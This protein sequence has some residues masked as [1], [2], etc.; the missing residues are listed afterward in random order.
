MGT[1]ILS[2]DE[3]LTAQL[4]E[5]AL[6]REF[7][8]TQQRERL[9]AASARVSRML[10]EATDVMAA[11]PQ[12]LRAL[13]EAAEV[14]RTVL[15]LAEIGADN[16]RWL[17]I[18]S[19]WLA[20]GIGTQG[21]VVPMPWNARKSDCFCSQLKTGRSVYLCRGDEEASNDSSIASAFAKSSIIVPFL[22]DGE[23]MGVV[24]FDACR[25]AREFDPAVISA[26]EIA[27][28]VIGAALHRERLIET[29]RIEREQAAEQR[30]SQ[31]ANANAALRA[32]LE[33]LASSPDPYNF[34]GAVLQETTR[35]LNAAA[36][37]VMMLNAACDEWRVMANVRDGNIE[38]PRFANAL[39]NTEEMYAEM[40]SKIQQQPLYYEIDYTCSSP[41][42]GI[43]DYQRAEQHLSI[44]KMPLVFGE[45]L[46][47]FIT[48]AFR[49]RE[50]LNAE[51]MEW[52][53]AITQQVTLA[54]GLKR[55]GVSSKNAAVLAERN[56]IGREIHD[57]LA[58]AFT[59]I[60]MQ[61]GAAEEMAEGSP[62]TP[63]LQRI[64]DI[65]REG[66]NE[67]RRSV[68]ALRPTEARPGGLQLALQ[69]LAERSTI[70]GRLT[71]HF[72]G[73]E[74]PTGLA[75]EHEHALLRIAQEAVAN[76]V[77]HAQPN[78]IKIALLSDG[79][80]LVLTVSD[81]GCGMGQ[82]PELYA[83]HGFGLTNMRERAEA[84]GGHWD[85]TSSADGGTL[86]SVRI[87]Q[88]ASARA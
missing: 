60:L 53:I 56:R 65:A 59:G 32:N 68:L 26:L 52:L 69:Q 13:G 58:Q 27:A 48:L 40:R 28:S 83:Q 86:I 4:R 41:W 34:L 22:I 9:W 71:S 82:M 55:L 61:L 67:A 11:M 14:D 66:L 10:L 7:P 88:Q 5:L 36:G 29:V 73:E 77:R 63:L 19:E 70:P 50:R 18:K 74:S 3:H 24:G 46:V 76:A 23:Y 87:P 42:P 45:H 57:G 80:H 16:E 17:V 25:Q 78:T 39:P 31:L 81:D 49:H 44:F 12:V 6:A 72:A 2:N 30:L 8:S 33:R 20:D 1:S 85:I 47:G 84:I 37:W 21:A 51:Q 62:L 54:I 64:G 35:Q 79:E 15:A 38:P 75:P 43:A